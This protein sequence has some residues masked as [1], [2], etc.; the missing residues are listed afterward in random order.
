M[1]SGLVAAVYITR[2]PPCHCSWSATAFSAYRAWCWSS[3]LLFSEARL[4]KQIRHECDCRMT[5]IQEVCFCACVVLVTVFLQGALAG[6][7]APATIATP[8]P[9]PPHAC[10]LH[11]ANEM[12]CSRHSA[13]YAAEN[14]CGA[15]WAD[16]DGK[17]GAKCPGGVDSE[18]PSGETCFGQLDACGSSSS[19]SGTPHPGFASAG[20]GLRSTAACTFRRGRT[21]CYKT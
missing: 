1:L 2:R 9:P 15:G 7:F 3:C 21:L 17:C 18:C 13:C 10:F 16:A 19:G 4:H 8:P 5:R 12:R 11:A 20:L 14:R 6:A